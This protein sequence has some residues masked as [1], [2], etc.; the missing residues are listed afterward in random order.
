MSTP[1]SILLFDLGGVL[2]ESIHFDELKKLMASSLSDQELRNIWMRSAA[3]REFEGGKIPPAQFGR[4]ITE[5]L[6][7]SLSGDDFIAQFTLWPKGFYPGAERL[8]QH[9]RRSH[10]VGCL[11][12][13]NHLH[14][15]AH[16]EAEFDFAYSSHLTGF[17]KPDQMAFEHVV[18]AQG[19]A[20]QAICFFDDSLINI[21]GARQA[22]M[23]A[24][25][26][27]G[28]EALVEVLE[29][30]LEFSLPA[31]FRMLTRRK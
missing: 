31:E 9:L 14:W 6:G 2:I 17:M 24:H 30:R 18:R 27:V 8:I 21:E 1:R 16:I 3:V 15:G 4:R 19:V 13:S 5:E 26:A 12:N 20:P 7:L 25:H 23:E 10:R 11:S 22:G 28:L 29:E